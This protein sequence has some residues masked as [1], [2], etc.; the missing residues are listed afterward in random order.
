M[1]RFIV[2]P[3]VVEV[4]IQEDRQKQEEFERRVRVELLDRLPRT[5]IFF[6]RVPE[7]QIEVE[8][9]GMALAK[10]SPRLAN[11]PDQ[12]TRLRPSDAPFLRRSDRCERRGDASVLTSSECRRKAGTSALRIVAANELDSLPSQIA[13]RDALATHFRY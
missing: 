2:S 4:V 9:I 13:Q 7:G 6:V 5:P 1:P 3:S 8:L 12:R 10:N 11:F